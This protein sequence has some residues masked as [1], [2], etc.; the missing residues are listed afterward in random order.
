LFAERQPPG[1]QGARL[2]GLFNDPEQAPEHG[3]F[4]EIA[5][6]LVAALFRL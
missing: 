2:L 6:E 4:R 3:P 1:G 5:S